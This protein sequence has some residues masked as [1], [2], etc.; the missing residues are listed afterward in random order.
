MAVELIPHD[1]PYA[2]IVF[3]DPRPQAV[4]VKVG[5][6][7]YRLKECTE[8]AYLDYEAARTKSAR[9]EDGV[10]TGL[11]GAVLA[12]GALLAACLFKVVGG[13]D[14]QVEQ[15][16]NE[17]WVRKLPARVAKPLVERLKIISGISDLETAD[18]LRRRMA[19]DAKKLEKLEAGRAG[20]TGP[21]GSPPASPDTSGSAPSAG[22]G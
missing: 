21:K 18:Q 1:D 9:L 11:G 5:E 16:V 15:P 3:A 6:D 20:D 22:A 2:D 17:A 13:P 12:E 10:L 4:N 19:A 7:R 14:S 8:A